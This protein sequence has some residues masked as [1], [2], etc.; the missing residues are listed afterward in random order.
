LLQAGIT[1]G[2][3]SGKSLVCKIFQCLGTP[4]YDADSRARA[5]MT[6]DEI[7]VDQIKK[8]FG[9]EAYNQDGSL[10]RKH[11]GEKAF[12][13]PEKLKNLDKLV[14]PRVALD[15]SI[16]VTAQSHPYVIKE[17]ALLYEAGSYKTL[18]KIIVVSAPEELRVKRV[19]SRDPHRSP[20]MIRDI[21]KNQMPESEKVSRADFVIVNDESQLV[22][23]QVIAIHQYLLSSQPKS[24]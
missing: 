12:G 21:I 14:H 22:I 15:Y 8:E 19:T 7:L 16:W 1:G 13:H 23:P 17:A 11:I 3:G 20:Q 6:A 24:Y 9:K 10:N 18:D 4:V 2:I 5:L